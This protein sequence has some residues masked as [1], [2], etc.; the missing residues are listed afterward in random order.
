[1][2]DR[3]DDYVVVGKDNGVVA[4]RSSHRRRDVHHIDTAAKCNTARA[5][6]AKAGEQDIVALLG[7][8]AHVQV[9]FDVRISRNF[10]F[11]EAIENCYSKCRCRSTSTPMESEPS[12]AICEKSLAAAMF[13]VDRRAR[14][15][16][17]H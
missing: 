9:R 1:M 8:Q 4:N 12:K 15:S 7:L 11:D 3:L 17:K 16:M 5:S 10:S 14:Q 6:Q 2:I 13:T